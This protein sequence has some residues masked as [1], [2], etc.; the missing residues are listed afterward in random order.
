MKGGV[1]MLFLVGKFS[2]SKENRHMMLDEAISYAN[3][4]EAIAYADGIGHAY[5]A[6]IKDGNIPILV[7]DTDAED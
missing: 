6:L 1:V 7:Y 4:K 5:I 2:G 3:L